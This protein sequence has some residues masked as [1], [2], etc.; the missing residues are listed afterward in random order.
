MPLCAVGGTAAPGRCRHARSG[1]V[2]RARTR[3]YYYARQSVRRFIE[4]AHTQSRRGR[5]FPLSLPLRRGRARRAL[6]ARTGLG[7]GAQPRRR[8]AL[9]LINSRTV[10]NNA[11]Q[12]L[13]KLDFYPTLR[14]NIF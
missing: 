4:A 14:L 12:S 11:M 6:A 10:P 7:G 2:E 8:G 3:S 13:P 9:I 5:R 1:I